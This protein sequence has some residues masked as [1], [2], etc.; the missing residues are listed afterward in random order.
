MDILQES[1][2]DGLSHDLDEARYLV[3]KATTAVR[4]RRREPA[5]RETV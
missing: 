3:E 2:G 5:S 4:P 1:L